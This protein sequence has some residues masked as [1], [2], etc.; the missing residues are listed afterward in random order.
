MGK[1]TL[2][3]SFL[4]LCLLAGCRRSGELQPDGGSNNTPFSIS[5]VLQSNMVLQRNQPCVLWGAVTAGHKVVV[6]ASWDVNSYTAIADDKGVWK[7]TI[8]PT[9]ANSLSQTITCTS[10]GFDDIKLSNIL[11]G[12]VWLC[13]GQ[14]NMV[15][16]VDALAPFT[17]VVNYPTEIARADIQNDSGLPMEPF[18][19]DN[20][21]D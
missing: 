18:R 12:D 16:Q 15:M 11:I 13:S 9:D 7:I 8:P 1:K 21:A 4:L 5:N 10:Q 20:W 14:S 6:K 3:F 19:T 17:G 2:L